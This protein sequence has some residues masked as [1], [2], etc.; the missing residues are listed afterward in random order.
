[1]NY[2]DNLAVEDKPAV[3]D[4]GKPMPGV[5]SY[6]F[7]LCTYLAK[8]NPDDAIRNA[9]N[10]MLF[11]T[12]IYFETWDWADGFCKPFKYKAKWVS[13]ETEEEEGWPLV[14]STPLQAPTPI[15]VAPFPT[16]TLPFYRDPD[17]ILDPKEESLVMSMID[18]MTAAEVEM[19]TAAVADVA[20]EETALAATEQIVL[21][22]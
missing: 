2:S 19:P 6:A 15:M 5:K 22:L 13:N 7:K 21:E 16:G 11:A 4:R 14:S 12:A 10:Y 20:A 17:V 18:S 8:A 1:M 9:E 3:D